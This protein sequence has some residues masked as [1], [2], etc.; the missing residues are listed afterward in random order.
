M[1]GMVLAAGYGTRFRPVTFDVPKPLIPLANKPLIDYAI[2][3]LLRAGVRDLVVN[4]HHLPEK[5]EQRV[6]ATFGERCTLH[7]SFEPE[8]LGTGGGVRKVADILRGDEPFLLVNGDT[9]QFPP[10]DE[11]ERCRRESG[12]VAAL[13]LRHPPQNDRFTRVHFDGRFVTGFGEGS[14]ES[15]MFSGS[16]AIS[17]AMF[18]WLPDRDFSGITE[19]VYIPITRSGT[20]CLA[21]VV[22]DGP[23]F[24]IGTPLRF[25][26]AS[27]EM[28]ALMRAGSIETTAGS[29]LA[30]DS[31]VANEASVE[32]EV[33][34]TTVGSGCGV[35][36]GAR[37]E[38][39]V[40]WDGASIGE[41]AAVRD[42]IISFGV[43]L[44]NG[45]EV[46]NALVT[47]AREGVAVPR[48]CVCLRG[49][50]ATPIDP[51]RP[52]GFA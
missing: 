44:P 49:L 4:L 45:A 39:S 28:I 21:G 40:V 11:L 1:K 26:S 36:R 20:A 10:F 33:R 12:A 29:D 42:S 30:G 17:R 27:R 47:K 51:A 19:D 48:E 34:N 14:G 5:L 38:S 8:I 43:K 7:F 16:H 23:W 6:R 18:D 24:D 46:A 31:L 13:L 52:L 25:L 32:G 35:G 41:G 2:E 50:V 22:Y 9:V 37:L 15:L 3:S